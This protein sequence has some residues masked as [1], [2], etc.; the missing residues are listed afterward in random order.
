MGF[1]RAVLKHF[2]CFTELTVQNIPDTTR[3]I[4]LIGPNGCGKSSFFDALN[5]HK[6]N[7]NA[8]SFHNDSLAIWETDYHDKIDKVGT[9]SSELHYLLPTHVAHKICIEPSQRPF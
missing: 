2:R 5:F 3:L 7:L 9:V 4:L 8:I 1:K 6:R